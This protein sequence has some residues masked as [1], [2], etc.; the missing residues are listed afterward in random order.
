[1]KKEQYKFCI[2]FYELSVKYLGARKSLDDTGEWE[3]EQI[4]LKRN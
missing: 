4:K 3:K 1:M 2:D